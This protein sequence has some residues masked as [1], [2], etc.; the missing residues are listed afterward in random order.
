MQVTTILNLVKNN[1][2]LG[3]GLVY[4]LGTD[5]DTVSLATALSMLC[6]S[7]GI[8]STRY[9]DLMRS[10]ALHVAVHDRNK[11]V[12]VLAIAMDNNIGY[13]ELLCVPEGLKD[14]AAVA[15]SATISELYQ[16]FNP[17]YLQGCGLVL[18]VSSTGSSGRSPIGGLRALGDDIDGHNIKHT[19]NGTLCDTKT[20]KREHNFASLLA[21][22]NV[23]LV[24]GSL[25]NTKAN[26]EVTHTFNVSIHRDCTSTLDFVD[27]LDA[28]YRLSKGTKEK[29]FKY[30]SI[31]HSMIWEEGLGFNICTQFIGGVLKIKSITYAQHMSSTASLPF[32]RKSLK[33]KRSEVAQELMI[34][35]NR[36]GHAVA[37]HLNRLVLQGK[38]HAVS[39]SFTPIKSFA[40]EGGEQA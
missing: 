38:V 39:P 30:V 14:V 17:D 22:T 32:K 35:R 18:G 34:C 27:S 7:G 12:E 19:A 10:L 11:L 4:V 36:L 13:N 26:D 29:I 3:D 9:T 8:G 37:E 33:R 28:D 24:F 5:T 23:H 16:R 1:G 6:I 31:L 25:V 15:W 40:Q 21:S 2:L 20:N